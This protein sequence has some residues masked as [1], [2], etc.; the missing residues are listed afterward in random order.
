MESPAQRER[1]IEHEIAALD[2][3]HE[4]LFHQLRQVGD[5]RAKLRLQLHD[6]Q[7]E[8]AESETVNTEAK[9]LEFLQAGTD[10]IA[11]VEHIKNIME[12]LHK[13]KYS[14]NTRSSKWVTIER[15]FSVVH[16]M[17]FDE[18]GNAYKPNG[19]VVKFNAFEVKSHA[20]LCELLK[21]FGN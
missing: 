11:L 10:Y 15:F 8:R 16:V 12:R 2:A 13:Q 9:A 17:R 7:R 20:E 19:R 4:S 18:E 21:N 5:K 3:E 6:V 1:Y 14:V